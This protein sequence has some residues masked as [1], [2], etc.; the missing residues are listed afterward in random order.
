MMKE[1]SARRF[2]R[3]ERVLITF[4]LFLVVF[5]LIFFPLVTPMIT[6]LYSFSSHYELEIPLL[7]IYAIL[8][9]LLWKSARSFN[10]LVIKER[11]REIDEES[12]S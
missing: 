2:E 7:L 9:A 8:W 6:W 3:N 10:K 11:L 1:K 4:F 12:N 5:L